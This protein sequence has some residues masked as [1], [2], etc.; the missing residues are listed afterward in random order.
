MN[1]EQAARRLAELRATLRPEVLEFLDYCNDRL[2]PQAYLAAIK[3]GFAP[4]EAE[5]AAARVVVGAARAM[6]AEVNAQE[7]RER[8][9]LSKN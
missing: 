1:N 7:N 3:I 6:R 5:R 4:L 9:G 8:F 2:F